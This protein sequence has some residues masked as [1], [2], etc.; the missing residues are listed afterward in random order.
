M[1]VDLWAGDGRMYKRFAETNLARY[2]AV[3]VSKNMLAK[4]PSHPCVR[5]IHYNLDKDE[6]TEDTA[7]PMKDATYDVAVCFFTLEYI[8]DLS[9]FFAQTHRILKP[10]SRL[11]LGYF[12]QRRHMIFDHAATQ[13]KIE[14][15][16]HKFEDILASC[17]DA[18]FDV[19]VEEIFEKQSFDKQTHIWWI[20]VCD[21]SN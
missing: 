21:K 5:K 1:V 14:T 12:L 20:L 9:Y 2:D 18:L 17:Q 15:Q 7:W 11:I 13:F 19:H 6:D 16:T 8:K 10:W 3:D 4:H